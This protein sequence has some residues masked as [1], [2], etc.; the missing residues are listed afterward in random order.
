MKLFLI[1]IYLY[2]QLYIDEYKL[3]IFLK[4]GQI[5]E[6]GTIY[7]FGAFIVFDLL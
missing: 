6:K 4:G 7:L 1:L 2:S 3:R 5:N